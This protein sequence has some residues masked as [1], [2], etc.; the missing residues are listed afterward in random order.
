MM[1]S[2][3]WLPGD[4]RE[5]RARPGWRRSRPP[6]GTRCTPALPVKIAWPAFGS[7]G[8]SIDRRAAARLGG[9]DLRARRRASRP[10]FRPELSRKATTAHSSLRFSP[11]GGFDDVG[12]DVG[13]AL[14]PRRRPGCSSDSTR[15]AD[16]L[17]AGLRVAARAPTPARSGPRP[18]RPM[19]W[20]VVHCPFSRKIFSRRPRAARA[21]RCRPRAT[22][23]RRLRL[24]LGNRVR[25]P[26]VAAHDREGERAHLDRHRHRSSA[27][28]RL[29]APAGDGAG[30]GWPAMGSSAAVVAL[31]AE[32]A[33]P[34][35]EHDHQEE[36]GWS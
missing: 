2:G 8:S 19:P 9:R 30:A 3:V 15:Y 10:R 6:C 13:E 29:R 12:H 33:E 16:R 20:H 11:I 1:Y 25:V 36:H 27:W 32:P 28:L 35:D 34:E 31:L 22:A 5:V 24:D 18:A 26:G 21:S 4:V 17:R 7:P 23:P 14:A